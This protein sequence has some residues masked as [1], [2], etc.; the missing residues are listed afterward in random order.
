V[1]R[2]YD[3]DLAFIHARGFGELAGAAAV[4][5][6]PLLQARGARR[7]VD[8][9]CGA[10][11]STKALVDAGFDVRAPRGWPAISIPTGPCST[12]RTSWVGHAG[13]VGCRRGLDGLARCSIYYLL[14][15]S[16]CPRAQMRST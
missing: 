2:L 14:G 10:G 4:A 6:I 15:Y 9:G 1:T 16:T 3:D 13:F 5:V 11:V 8:V 7:V 12:L